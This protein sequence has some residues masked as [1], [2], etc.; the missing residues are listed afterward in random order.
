MKGDLGRLPAWKRGWIPIVLFLAAAGM[1]MAV[2][3][4]D[5]LWATALG[6]AL[7]FAIRPRRFGLLR[8][9]EQ[10]QARLVGSI[11]LA[12]NAMTSAVRYFNWQ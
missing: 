12:G 2:D 11:C 4:P 7:W 6:T 9:D 1:P 3:R 10:R 8:P 5:K